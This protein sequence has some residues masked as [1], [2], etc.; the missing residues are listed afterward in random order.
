MK[1]LAAILL[2]VLLWLPTP[3]FAQ[4]I[5]QGDVF[6]NLERLDDQIDQLIDILGEALY[7]EILD[8]LTDSTRNMDLLL[9]ELLRQREADRKRRQPLG[10]ST[11][12]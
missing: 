5:E 4:E 6:E 3:S 12:T 10:D 2:A 11:E 9:E 1:R 7:Y 8:L